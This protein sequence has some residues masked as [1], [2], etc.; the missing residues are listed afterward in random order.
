MWLAFLE[1]LIAFDFDFWQ[2]LEKK[3]LGVRERVCAGT[4]QLAAEDFAGW[5]LDSKI[6]SVER[7]IERVLERGRHEGFDLH[8][9]N[10]TLVPP[11]Q[12]EEPPNS[13]V[14]H[15]VKFSL[16]KLNALVNGKVPD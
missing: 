11:Q 13:T 6:A 5:K 2:E 16:S 14:I 3:K 12:Q 4:A 10:A 8:D 1:F 15:K 7:K 9:L